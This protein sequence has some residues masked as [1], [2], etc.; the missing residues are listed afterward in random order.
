MAEQQVAPSPQIVPSPQL[1]APVADSS[2]QPVSR[3]YQCHKCTAG[4]PVTAAMDLMPHQVVRYVQLGLEEELLKSKTIWQ[5]A[6]CRTCISR[7]PNGIDIAAINDALKQR[8]LARGIQ[9]ALP[10]VAAF[11]QAFLASVKSKGRVYELGMLIVFKLKTG[12][13]F[14]D[15]PLGLKMF[16][17]RKLRLLPEGIKNRQRFRALLQGEKGWQE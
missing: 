9:P 1:I 17:R 12:T 2:G 15:V 6:A 4:C 5:C 7:C 16:Q 11:H 8:A 14:R 13:Y 10:E 3:C